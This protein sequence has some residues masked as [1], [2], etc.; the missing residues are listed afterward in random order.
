MDTQ[1]FLL[2]IILLIFKIHL[3]HKSYPNE[4]IFR[5]PSVTLIWELLSSGFIVKFAVPMYM[6]VNDTKLLLYLQIVNDH[7][8][9][10]Y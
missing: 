4:H 9:L 8:V 2:C 10:L 1:R 6:I 3:S 7:V 5:F